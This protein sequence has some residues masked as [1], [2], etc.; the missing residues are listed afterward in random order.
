VTTL[1]AM[2]ATSPRHHL[3]APAHP[4][5]GPAVVGFDGSPT[6]GRALHLV[7]S[8]LAPDGQ[9]LVVAVEP[10][11][12]SHGMLSEPLIESGLNGNALVDGAL[13]RL[14][15]VAPSSLHVETIVRTGN[16]GNA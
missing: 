8:A 12:R 1:R 7:A 4:L 11:M 2:L 9:L 14:A 6:A 16:R 5:A 3:R 15:D 13:E 10:R